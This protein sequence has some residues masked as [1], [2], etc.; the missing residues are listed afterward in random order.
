MT[1]EIPE[2][3]A[4]GLREFGLVTGGIFAGLFGVV[5]PWIF[6]LNFPVWPWILA[7]V[8][9]I[10][11]LLAPASLHHPYHLWM[12]L[13]LAIGWVMNRVV[14]AVVFFVVMLPIGLIMRLRGHDPMSRKLDTE[15]STY[16]VESR[17]TKPDQ[18]DRPY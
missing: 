4:K 8:L 15:Q 9:V 12:R 14:L 7:A 2:L 1:E 5:I 3:D 16:R 6:G 11:A 18:M 10:W 13:G 17:P